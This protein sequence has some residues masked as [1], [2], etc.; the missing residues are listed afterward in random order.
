MK[1]TQEIPDRD[2]TILYGPEA[3]H[4]GQTVHLAIRLAADQARGCP[5]T[6]VL[7]MDPDGNSTDPVALAPTS[8]QAHPGAL[9]SD[10]L[11]LQAP[12]STGTSRWMA[13]LF[14]QAEDETDI[15]DREIAFD[16]PITGHPVAVSVW[17]VPYGVEMGAEFTISVGLK[18]TCG[19]A[20][21]GWGF[22]VRDAAGTDLAQAQVGAAPAAGTSGLCQTSVTLTAPAQAGQHVW[23]VTALPP[24]T[25]LAHEGA[26]VPIHID[27]RP[28]PE[29]TLRV[30]A[31]DAANGQP[32]PRAK[33]VAH[34]YRTFT[35]SNGVALLR[36][37]KGPY[38]VYV[39]GKTYFASQTQETVEQ[40][41]TIRAALFTDREFSDADHW[42]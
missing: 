5:A 41:L 38:R 22:V 28:A 23:Q 34:P 16:L 42:A 24:D 1:L 19:C 8:G 30:E 14:H 9:Q 29:V 10:P 13:V 15:I 25:G 21:E 6:H 35:D 12:L 40:D 31:F 32:V 26:T 18:C 4:I 11:T 3:V 39:S 33:V 37:P 36:L 17:D 20:S 7:F 27:A 2:G